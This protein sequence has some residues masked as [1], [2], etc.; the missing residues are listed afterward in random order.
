MYFTQLLIWAVPLLDARFRRALRRFPELCLAGTCLP[1]VS[2]FSRPMR[3][4]ALATTHRWAGAL[5]ML[6]A[7]S[8]DEEH[9]MALGYAAHLLTDIVAHN[10]FVPSHERRWLRVPLLTHASAEWAMDAH[11]TA[12]LFV[13]PGELILRHRDVLV[14]YAGHRLGIERNAA[15]RALHCLGTGEKLLRASRLPQLVYAAARRADAAL[16]ARF[17][18]YVSETA[19]RLQQIN[20][21][22][23][24]ETPGWLPDLNP[25]DARAPAPEPELP[26]PYRL[27][28]PPDWFHDA[29]SR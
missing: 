25:G 20:R 18:Q 8:Q 1:D 2:L 21:L 12:H 15:A 7:A 17:D 6:R 4:P 14:T 9:A 28:L 29:R 10:Y 27:L 5:A 19:S 16:P 13:T 22:I 24:G 23:G 3:A 11:V 26:G